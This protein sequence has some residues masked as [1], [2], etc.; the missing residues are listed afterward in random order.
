[1]LDEL[2]DD[3]FDTPTLCAGWRVRDVVSRMLLAHTTPLPSVLG[4]LAKNGFNVPKTS[5]TTSVAY[6]SSH[7]ISEIR[8]ERHRVVDDREMKGF[9]KVVPTKEAFVGLPTLPQHRDERVTARQTSAAATC[10]F[11]TVRVDV[12]FS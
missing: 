7:S 4:V 3:A 11:A 8:A 6:G 10:C 12:A 2:D 1:M 5:L 9:G